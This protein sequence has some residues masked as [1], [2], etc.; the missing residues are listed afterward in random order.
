MNDL[1]GTDILKRVRADIEKVT[2]R[3]K[4]AEE[5][6]G[7]FQKLHSE[8]MQKLTSLRETEIY[9]A[10][11]LPLE[12]ERCDARDD[13]SLDRTQSEIAGHSQS[14]VAGDQLPIHAEA[15]IILEENGKPMSTN[16]IAKH[17]IRRGCKL[18]SDPHVRHSA[19]YSAM[20]RKKDTFFKYSKSLWGLVGRDQ[21]DAQQHDDDAEFL[22][23][24]SAFER[25]IRRQN[26]VLGLGVSEKEGV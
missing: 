19:V 3:A 13:Q 6:A 21:V 24:P 15:S 25:A 1:Q 11:L 18:P 20:F 17:M 23:S 5:E 7:R 9:V 10:S 12:H 14:R 2:V 4:A 16:D 8:L 26:G 22:G